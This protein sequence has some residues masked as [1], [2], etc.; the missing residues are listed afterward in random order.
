MRKTTGTTRRVRL[1]VRVRVAVWPRATSTF[2]R[3][4]N[5]VRRARAAE[6]KLLAARRSLSSKTQ[7]VATWPP[8]AG[9]PG[10]P[11]PGTPGNA[12]RRIQ[13]RIGP[14]A[15]AFGSPRYFWARSCR[16]S[17]VPSGCLEEYVH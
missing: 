6:H 12:G 4:A 13:G 15:A 16:A 2:K 9:G 7:Q 10:Q 1:R 8:L 11:A 5:S 14:A 3:T 17:R